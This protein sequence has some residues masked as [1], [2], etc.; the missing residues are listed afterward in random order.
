MFDEVSLEIIKTHMN[1]DL[2]NKHEATEENSI[3][4]LQIKGVTAL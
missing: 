3:P 1:F 4:D 2:K